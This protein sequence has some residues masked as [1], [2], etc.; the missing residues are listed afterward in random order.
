MGYYENSSCVLPFMT[1]LVRLQN[2]EINNN[3]RHI[4]FALGSPNNFEKM[5]YY[6][7]LTLGSRL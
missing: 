1:A 3:G 6:P 5:L 7:Y 2:Y 4:I